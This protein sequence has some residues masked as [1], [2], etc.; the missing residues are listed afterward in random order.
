MN[1]EKNI[2]HASGGRVPPSVRTVRIASWTKS[3]PAEKVP[4]VD[5]DTHH[6]PRHLLTFQI[7]IILNNYLGSKKKPRKVEIRVYVSYGNRFSFKTRAD[8]L[9]TRTRLHKFGTS[10]FDTQY[11]SALAE[12]YNQIIIQGF[13]Q[14]NS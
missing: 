10:V 5:A 11:D 3:L 8:I 14:I 9:D 13:C 2:C 4:S 1:Q 7:I 12:V 6:S